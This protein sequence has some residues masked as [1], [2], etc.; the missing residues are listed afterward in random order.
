VSSILRR[1]FKGEKIDKYEITVIGLDNAGKTTIVNRLLRA[2]FIPTTRTLGVNYR[3]V[4]YRNIE[5]NMVDLG[6][7]R[8][9]R[10]LLWHDSLETASAIVFVLDSADIRLTE[11]SNAFWD[12]IKLNEKAPVLFIANKIDLPGARSFDMIVKDLDLTRATRTTGRPVGLFRISA[13]TGAN[14][15]DAFDW[16]ADVLTGTESK[17]KC[18]VRVVI[19][20]DLETHQIWTTKFTNIDRSI[21][22]ELNKG[23]SE[24]M[25]LLSQN[26]SGMEVITASDLQLAVVKNHPLVVGLI[27]GYSDSVVR[28][29]LIAERL[30]KT[31]SSSIEIGQYDSRIMTKLLE[32]QWP[33]DI[34][35][36][37][38]NDE[39]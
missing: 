8:I 4:K 26:S 3:T 25:A 1:I 7:Q 32:K 11:A 22:D 28:A 29:K 35:R 19:M 36:P 10:N 27:I 34:Y 18:K 24:T 31:A 37:K 2:E 23:I 30:M 6:G 16:L 38:P 21:L 14:F 15:Y 9:Y 12:S 5:F 39:S 17:F 20:I 33:L 13:K